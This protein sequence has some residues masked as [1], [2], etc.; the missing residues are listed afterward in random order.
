[1]AWTTEDTAWMQR[2]MAL[3]RTGNA[4]LRRD[5]IGRVIVRDGQLIGADCKEELRHDA[6]TPRSFPVGRPRFTASHKAVVA[7]RTATFDTIFG[8]P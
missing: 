7:R 2:A 5:G 6:T 3:T 8:R 4:E 1:M